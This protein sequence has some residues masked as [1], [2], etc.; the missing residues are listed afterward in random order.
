MGMEFIKGGI[1]I[2][3]F[4]ICKRSS[5]NFIILKSKLHNYI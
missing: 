1:L 5:G 2:Y 3:F 4:Q